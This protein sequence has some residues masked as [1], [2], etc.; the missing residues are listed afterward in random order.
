MRNLT[1]NSVSFP[2][3]HFVMGLKKPHGGIRRKDISKI[4]N[5]KILMVNYE[6]PPLGG[7]G[8]VFNKQVAEE[9]GKDNEITVITSNFDNQNPHETINNVEVIRVPVLMRKDQNIA[10]LIS[11]IF[12]FP[13]QFLVRV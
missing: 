13:C 2:K 4:I 1:T 7:G 8:G 12:L 5:M 9:L 10:S 11:M 6:Y 3:F